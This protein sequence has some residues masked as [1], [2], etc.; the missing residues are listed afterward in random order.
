[1]DPSRECEEIHA[2]GRVAERT[3]VRIELRSLRAGQRTCTSMVNLVRKYKIHGEGY[4]YLP[5]GRRPTRR[6][7]GRVKRGPEALRMNV[8]GPCDTDADHYLWE[9]RD[10]RISPTPHAR[11]VTARLR[12][13]LRPRLTKRRDRSAARPCTAAGSA[14]GAR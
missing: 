13:Q 9:G 4:F 7:A 3:G 12:L 11:N 2:F 1:M 8:D 5:V 10:Q 14:G 6:A